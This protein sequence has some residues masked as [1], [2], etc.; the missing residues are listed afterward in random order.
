MLWKHISA[1]AGLAATANAFMI[2]PEISTADSDIVEALPFVE[3]QTIGQ[4]QTLKLDCPG[5][6]VKIRHHDGHRA[7]K[8]DVA[9]HLELTFSIDTAGEVDSLL[10]NDFQLYPTSASWYKTLRAPQV[11][12]I[13]SMATKHPQ[14]G[15]PAMPQLG[16]T[17]GI[18]PVPTEADDQHLSLVEVDLQIIEVGYSF[19]DAIPAVSLKLIETP[20]GKLMIAS[21]DVVKPEEETSKPAGA[22]EE[23]CQNVFCSWRQSIVKGFKSMAPQCHKGHGH[24]H[25]QHRKPGHYKHRHTWGRL[26]QNITWSIV[27]PVLIGLVAG[28]SVALIGMMMGTLVV[29]IWRLVFRRQTPWVRRQCR[30]RG[31]HACHKADE[32]GAALAAE[33]ASL[34]ENQDEDVPDLPA[35]SETDEKTT[36]S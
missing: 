30:R 7:S 10:V 32:D 15:Q 17:L 34:M 29:F 26:L 20:S 24:A 9:N 14:K 2:V 8:M 36:R 3:A 5:C 19:N 13:T 4:S 27:L 16:Y 21:I 1:A 25:A 28:V 11:L 23:E 22:A 31:G 33:K 6:P 12:D 18:R 35:Y